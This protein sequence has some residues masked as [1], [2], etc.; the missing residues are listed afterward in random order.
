MISK[1]DYTAWTTMEGDDTGYTVR[2]FDPNI[3]ASR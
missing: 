3:N 2:G 1:Q